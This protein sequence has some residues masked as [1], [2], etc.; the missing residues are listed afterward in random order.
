M[1]FKNYTTTIDEHKTIG[2][3]MCILAKNKAKQILTEYNDN[4]DVENIS[5]MYP[6]Q[7][8]LIGIKLPGNVE[9]VYKVMMRQRD[10]KEIKTKVDIEQARRN[11]KDWLEAQMAL[12]ETEQV[13]MEQIFLPYTLN[14][15]GKTFYEIYQ[16][17][18]LAD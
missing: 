17:K 5:F 6:Y 10:R 14:K 9:N 11:V 3:I 2:E 1:P 4:G 15:D 7:D 8:R 18:L 12:I 16:Q 13:K